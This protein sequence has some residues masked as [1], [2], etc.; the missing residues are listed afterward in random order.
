[1]TEHEVAHCEDKQNWGGYLGSEVRATFG[2]MLKDPVGFVAT[3]YQGVK[4]G[5]LKN[6]IQNILRG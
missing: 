3:V 1:V 2:P 4:E 6:V 5:R